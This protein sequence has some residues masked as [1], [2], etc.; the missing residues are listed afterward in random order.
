LDQKSARR[1]L[2]QLVQHRQKVE[3]GSEKEKSFGWRSWGRIGEV[4]V[5]WNLLSMTNALYDE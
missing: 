2:K 3:S 1:V 4:K 5:G